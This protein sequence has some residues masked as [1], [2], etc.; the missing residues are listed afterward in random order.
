MY[1]FYIYI[2]IFLTHLK[3]EIDNPRKHSRYLKHFIT[4]NYLS[5]FITQNYI[6]NSA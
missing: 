3:N 6:L 5:T 2:S 1:I 4:W